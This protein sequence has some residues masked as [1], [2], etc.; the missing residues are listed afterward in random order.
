L[1]AVDPNQVREA[2]ETHDSPANVL[3]ALGE[4]GEFQEQVIDPEIVIDFSSF[5]SALTPDAP[6]RFHGWEGWMEMW[7][8]WLGAWEDYE[9]ESEIEELDD[10]HIL[11][12]ATAT[13]KGRGSGV[14]IEW[15]TVGIWTVRDGRFLGMH[16]FLTREDALAAL[17]KGL[18]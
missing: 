12:T 4:F 17:E 7:R 11:I 14:E 2:L 15:V 13:L 18:P 1:A 5:D 10:E 9:P 6:E 8:L 16:N 3:A